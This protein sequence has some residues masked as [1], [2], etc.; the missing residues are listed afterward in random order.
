MNSNEARRQAEKSFK[1]ERASIGHGA[2][3]SY[4]VDTMAV[5]EKTTRLK[6]LRLAKEAVHGAAEPLR[7]RG[8]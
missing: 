2:K 7:R 6:A 3:P 5:R 1:H 4:E 8:I